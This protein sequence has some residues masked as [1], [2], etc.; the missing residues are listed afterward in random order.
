MKK[1]KYS[2]LLLLIVL[3]GSSCERKL[4]N[5]VPQAQVANVAAFS[6]AGRIQSQVLSLYGT[7]KSGSW[8]GGRY[9]IA[10]DVKADNFICEQN[11]LITDADVWNGNPTNSATAI[12]NEWS[13]AYLTINN[14]NN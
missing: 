10:G 4:L 11:N 14:C 2:I 12:I 5:P 13:A 1:N 6:T 9:Q 3:I 8:L 7:L